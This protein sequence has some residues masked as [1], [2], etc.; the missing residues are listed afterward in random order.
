VEGWI[1]LMCQV[2]VAGL[3]LYKIG[4]SK[5]DPEKRVKNLQTGNP[6]KILLVKKY[7]SSNYHKIEKWLHRKFFMDKTLSNNEWFNLTSAQANSFLDECRS[8]ESNI[9][10][11][12]S[13]NHF[14]K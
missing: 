6:N 7:K 14:Y 1:Y 10:Y 8:I 13:E 3:E 4:V 9:N 12:L 2:D 11:L 5:N